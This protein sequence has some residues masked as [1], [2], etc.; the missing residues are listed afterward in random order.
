MLVHR[1]ATQF[2][3]FKFSLFWALLTTAHL[4][5]AAP[6][7]LNY[8]AALKQAENYSAQLQANEYQVTSLRKRAQVAEQLPDPKF[9]FEMGDVPLNG[10]SR[11]RLTRESMAMQKYSIMQ[12]YVSDSKRELSAQSLQGEADKL[13]SNRE[14]LVAQL[15]RATARSWLALHINQKMLLLTEQLTQESHKQL[16]SLKQSQAN[17]DEGVSALL[18]LSMNDIALQDRLTAIQSEVAIEQ[19]SLAQLTGETAIALA[20]NAPNYFQL[21]AS[22][23]ELEAD[24]IHHPEIK[25]AYQSEQIGKVNRELARKAS[26]PDVDIE[27]YYQRS[28]DDKDERA[29][30]MFTIDLPI[31]SG[32]RQQQL[33]AAEAATTLS[34]S[35]DVVQLQREH[36]TQLLTLIS[37]Y[38]VRQAQ[39][40]RLTDQLTPLQ[41]RRVSLL[42]SEYQ[43]GRAS[44]PQLFAAKLQVLDLQL[45]RL[46]VEKALASL[47]VDIRYLRPDNLAVDNREAI[48]ALAPTRSQPI[49]SSNQNRK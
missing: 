33:Y 39:W 22:Q 18:E 34:L 41:Q 30:V 32:Q 40:Q 37:Q 6:A 16:Q 25:Q 48:S 15:Q 46:A 13:N 49:I 7:V 2:T 45:T 10:N 3:L 1:I 26:I 23:A 17:S 9:K 29:G 38:Q 21:P 43:A 35:Q 8:Q 11:G 4:V 14:V 20:G 42:I 44:L 24:I 19:Y 31:L 5:L 12:T 47:W 27:L 28:F 36:Q